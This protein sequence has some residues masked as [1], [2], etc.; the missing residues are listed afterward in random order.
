MPEAGVPKPKVTSG[1]KLS[2]P[3]TQYKF[4]TSDPKPE[5]EKSM[6]ELEIMN[7]A[8]TQ[9]DTTT[10]SRKQKTIFVA[11]V[12]PSEIIE[13]L[14]TNGKPYLRMPNAHVKT[15]NTERERNVMAF[16]KSFAD[17]RPSLTPGK[18]IDLAVQLDGGSMKIVGFPRAKSAPSKNDLQMEAAA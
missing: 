9:N 3:K 18:P 6:K 15:K 11:R 14:D 7:S 17:V 1:R 4:R 8:T 16:G 5:D 2:P 10:T 13:A 12:T